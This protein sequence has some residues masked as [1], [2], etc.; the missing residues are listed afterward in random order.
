MEET[1]KL[2][3][4]PYKQKHQYLE[5]YHSQIVMMSK[6]YSLRQ[7]SRMTR[8]STTTLLKLKKMFL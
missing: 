7:I 2:R 5:D 3:G 1:I 6:G 4:R 8:T